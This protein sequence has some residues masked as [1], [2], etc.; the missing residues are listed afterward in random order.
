MNGQFYFYGWTVLSESGKK[1]VIL[2]W[3]D[4]FGKWHRVGY[5]GVGV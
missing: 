2:S 5:K 3:N 4:N 1:T